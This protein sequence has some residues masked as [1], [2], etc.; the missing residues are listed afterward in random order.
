MPVADADPA[1]QGLYRAG[2]LAALLYVL[3]GVVIPTVMVYAE[4]Y[5]FHLTG[6]AMLAF[7]ASH[8]LWWTTLQTLVLGSGLLA[9]VVFVAVFVA[10]WPLDKSRAAVG[11][12]VAV[13]SQILFVAYYPVLLGLVYLSDRYAVA[14]A[15]ERA[16]LAAAADALLAM[17]NAINPIYEPVFAA[18]VSLL[19][20]IMLKGVFSRATAYIGLAVFPASIVGLALVPWL[21][22]GYLWWWILLV[23]WL[24]LVGITLVRLG[25]RRRDA[26]PQ[27][28]RHL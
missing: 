15:A 8:R 26:I 14:P 28:R 9:V 11:A 12:T 10:L 13:A 19:S 16:P 2:G 25:G 20:F 4:G 24:T 3:L 23:V 5:D 18:S 17:N 27:R 7:I 21:G 6:P 1:W 22:V